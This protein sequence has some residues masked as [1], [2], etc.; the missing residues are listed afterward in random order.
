M[1]LFEKIKLHTMDSTKSRVILVLGKPLVY[2]QRAHFFKSFT[3]AWNLPVKNTSIPVFYLKVNRL[4]DYTLP[5]IQHWINVI[6]NMGADFYFLCDN[7]K[8]Q[9]EILRWICFPNMNVK[10]ISSSK[11]SQLRKIVK[12]ISTRFWIKATYAHLTTFF[13]AKKTG[14]RS[15]WNIDADDTFFAM[16]IEKLS[17]YLKKVE[18]YA[19]AY[20]ISAFSLDMHRSR[21]FGRHW[22]FGI[23]FTRMSIDW[24]HILEQN[25]DSKWQKLYDKYDYEFNLDWFFTYLRDYKNLKIESFYLDNTMFIHWGNFLL[26]IIGAAVFSWENNRVKFPIIL[27]VLGDENFGD[28]PICPDCIKFSTSCKKKSNQKFISDHL[29]YLYKP[30]KQMENLWHK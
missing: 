6:N 7:K 19:E 24:F 5:C 8:L 22:S 3:F 30:S 29:T 28:I 27:G 13:H 9:N 21:T 1:R 12:N 15:F 10:F 23:T 17:K 16:P 2:Y 26:N 18:E 14:V 20:N 11:C 25:T 4:A